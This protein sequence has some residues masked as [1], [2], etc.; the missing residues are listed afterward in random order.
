MRV[1]VTSGGT[2]VPVDRVRDITNMSNGTFGA[3]IA[4]AALELEH[5]VC[6]FCAQHSR[7]PFSQNFDFYGNDDWERAINSVADL[8]NFCS[9]HQQRYTQ[10]TFRNFTDYEQGLRLS[11]DAFSPD[12]V[13]LAAA[14]SDYGVTNYMDGKI[15]SKKNQQILLEPLPK[16][17]SQVKRWWPECFLVGFKLLVESSEDE[18]VAAARDSIEKNGCDLVVANNL[19]S[20]QAGDHRVL[21]VGP[22]DVESYSQSQR[23][24]DPYYLARTVVR[25]ATEAASCVMSSSE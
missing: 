16:V 22:K 15:R 25:T 20:L 23:P 6:F 19:A 3:R 8:Y 21:I 17:I 10:V 12:V 9:K 13:I 18:L 24:K 14:V 11:L 1:L 4:H 5:E 2:K 7:T